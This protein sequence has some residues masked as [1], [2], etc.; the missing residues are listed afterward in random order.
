M[1]D[2]LEIGNSHRSTSLSP[3]QELMEEAPKGINMLEIVTSAIS[4]HDRLDQ[5]F[6]KRARVLC[7]L[8]S[9]GSYG[10]GEIRRIEWSFNFGVL[11]EKDRKI[12]RSSSSEICDVPWKR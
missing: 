4:G 6:L 5:C 12:D 1:S 11:F 2:Y 7:E 3:K 9:H 8:K 10:T